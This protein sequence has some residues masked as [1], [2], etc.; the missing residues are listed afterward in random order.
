M[1]ICRRISYRR[2][3]ACLSVCPSV[4]SSVLFV[5]TS[6]FLVLPWYRV[7]SSSHYRDFWIQS[8]CLECMKLHDSRTKFYGQNIWFS[9]WKRRT[10]KCC[11]E[12]YQMWYRDWNTITRFVWN[13]FC[14]LKVTNKSTVIIICFLT[15]LTYRRST[16]V[17]AKSKAYVCGRSRAAIMGS[18]PPETWMSVSCE[19]CVLSGRALCVVPITLP[20]ESCRV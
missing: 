2:R 19:Y 4:H 6:T 11:S 10:V 20:V 14:V 8:V 15:N 5:E 17:G 3:H 12:G 1:K 18:N 9:V 13:T 7:R 16:T